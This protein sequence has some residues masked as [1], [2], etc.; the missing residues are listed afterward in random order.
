MAI[1][2]LATT[3]LAIINLAT[4][5]LAKTSFEDEALSSTRPF[6]RIAAEQWVPWTR[7]ITQDDGNISISGPTANLLQVLAEKLNFDYE[8]V[9]PPDGYWGAEKADGSWSGM[10]GM[11]HRE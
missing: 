11:L 9:R 2:T 4:I 7:I 8:L 10:I 5:T 3:P 1:T 6:F